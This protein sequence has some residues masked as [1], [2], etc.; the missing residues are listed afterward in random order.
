MI[1]LKYTDIMLMV[2]CM[3]L[4]LESSLKIV[5]YIL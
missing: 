4:I 2:K 3:E 1:L 5:M